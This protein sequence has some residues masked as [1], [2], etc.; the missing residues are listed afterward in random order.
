[1]K[2]QK[3]YI[4]MLLL[5][6][7]TRMSYN[8]N[9]YYSDDDEYQD[10]RGYSKKVVTGAALT[11]ALLTGVTM[12]LRNRENRLDAHKLVAGVTKGARKGL[13]RFLSSKDNSV[14]HSVGHLTIMQIIYFQLVL[15]MDVQ[16]TPDMMSIKVIS[17]NI[18]S[19]TVLNIMCLFL[20]HNIIPNNIGKNKNTRMAYIPS[21]SI[22]NNDTR[23]ANPSTVYVQV[24]EAPAG[25]SPV[26]D[27]PEFNF[28]L[29]RVRQHITQAL[30]VAPGYVLYAGTVELYLNVQ[31]HEYNAWR[32]V[33]YIIDVEAQTIEFFDPAG[34]PPRDSMNNVELLG[35]YL[36]TYIFLLLHAASQFTAVNGQNS[37]L[38]V[39]FP[40][41]AD[42]S[43]GGKDILLYFWYRS[44]NTAALIRAAWSADFRHHHEK[45]EASL[46]HRLA[47]ALSIFVATLLQACS[48]NRNTGAAPILGP[49]Y[50]GTLRPLDIRMQTPEIINGFIRSTSLCATHELRE[51]IANVTAYLLKHGISMDTVITNSGLKWPGYK[52]NKN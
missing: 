25:A 40:I 29:T 19:E 52:K 27:T 49:F 39:D 51:L 35:M 17:N 21:I 10:S 30:T 34:W 6:N 43:N 36:R 47:V 24:V 42:T 38:V 32:S 8:P 9:Q 15:S 23:L 14:L 7:F 50:K 1:M 2:H 48:L 26:T 20:I 31:G 16:L 22:T 11:G 5:G 28:N 3:T 41:H 45:G 33:C 37:G 46:Q 4:I 13:L 44:E 12:W 18:E